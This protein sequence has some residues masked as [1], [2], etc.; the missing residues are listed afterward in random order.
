MQTTSP[1]N[2]IPHPFL[3]PS[4][5][6]VDGGHLIGRDPRTIGEAE[7]LDQMPDA[8]VG[9]RAIR[10]KCI[11]CMGG[12]RAEVRKCVSVSCAL[13]PLRMGSIPRGLA[14]LRRK[15]A[16]DADCEADEVVA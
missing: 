14:S 9:M 5:D 15:R 8:D 10:A 2:R 4:P 12:N 1:E 11:D 6:E 13:W 3:A 7:W 16:L